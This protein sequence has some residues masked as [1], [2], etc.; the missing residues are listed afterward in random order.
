MT[1]VLGVILSVN[2]FAVVLDQEQKRLEGEFV[3][4]SSNQAIALQ[5]NL[6]QRL[7]LLYSLRAFFDA[8]EH[9]HE[10]EFKIFAGNI[11]HRYPEIQALAWTPRVL[12]SQ[13]AEYE[14]S[15][16]L[17]ICQYSRVGEGEDRQRVRA[18][19]R[20]EYFPAEY[21]E[22]FEPNRTA[23]GFD[24][25]SESNRRRTL[26]HALKLNAL[27]TSGPIRLIPGVG[28]NLGFLVALPVYANTEEAVP[29]QPHLKGFVLA[30]FAVVDIFSALGGQFGQKNIEWA[31]CDE[32]NNVLFFQGSPTD[33]LRPV[34]DSSDSG[35]DELV[36]KEPLQVAQSFWAI[37]FYPSKAFFSQERGWQ[38]MAA[39][40]FGLSLTVLLAGYF[41]NNVRR[42]VRIERIVQERTADI[43]QMNQQ[44]ERE[45]DERKRAEEAVKAS[46][47]ETEQLLTSISSIMIGVDANDCISRWNKSAE[48]T[49]GVVGE[50]IIGLEFLECGIDWDWKNVLTAITACR[51]TDEPQWLDKVRFTH[52]KGREG[53]L[54]ITINPVLGKKGHA[55]YLLL[56]TEVTER[57]VLESQL[58]QAQKLESIGQLAAGIAHEINTPIQYVGDNTR[59]LED[60]FADFGKVIRGY[61]KLIAV[62]RGGTVDPDI[63]QNIQKLR[64]QVDLDYL[65]AESP[66]AIEQSLEGVER[67]SHIVQAMKAFSHPGQEMKSMMNVNKALENTITIARNEWKYVAEVETEFD[68]E[69]PLVPCLPREMNQV[70]LNLIVNAAQAIAEAVEEGMFMK[71]RITIRTSSDADYVEIAIKDNGKGIPEEIRAR[72][73]DPFFTTKQVG[74]GTGQGLAISHNVVVEQHGGTLCF[75]TEDGAGTAF[76]VRLSIVQPEPP[77]ES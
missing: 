43:M 55:G 41:Y 18:E 14:R 64:N 6:N 7:E 20:A 52:E 57:I 36:L 76:F 65:L 45:I 69:L 1:I 26:K 27:A 48:Q 34:F 17:E 70:F 71:G 2:F 33:G 50:Q 30:I 25:G 29:G 54:A 38:H 67:V 9:V 40:V 60:A 28:E 13:R 24:L 8:S 10:D 72:I 12:H 62:N 56:A 75:E 22:P 53:F 37:Q 74:K 46:H 77:D 15:R 51:N 32:E 23:L 73:F 11:L 19:T 44:L 61:D 59:F 4:V 39:L 49:F 58:T 47:T 66:I 16:T 35:N 31:I 68:P 21:I 5:K 63:V 3:R 42:T